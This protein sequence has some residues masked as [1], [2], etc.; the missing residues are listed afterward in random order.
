[1]HPHPYDLTRA[2]LPQLGPE[3]GLPPERLLPGP[4]HIHHPSYLKNP[5]GWHISNGVS[6]R[7]YYSLPI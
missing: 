7:L 2:S 3:A 6:L 4:S 1:M 5:S